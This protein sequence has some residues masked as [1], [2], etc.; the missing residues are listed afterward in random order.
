MA[1]HRTCPHCWQAHDTTTPCRIAAITE[2]LRRRGDQR[3]ADAAECVAIRRY[4]GLG[5]GSDQDA[6]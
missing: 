4:L 2:T 3:A 5:L 6:A 1:R